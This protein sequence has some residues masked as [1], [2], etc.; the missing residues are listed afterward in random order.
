MT[1]SEL[2]QTD[3]TLHD[4]AIERRIAGDL[5]PELT[6]QFDAHIAQNA[7]CRS[8]YQQ[9]YAHEEAWTPPAL[10]L[11]PKHTSLGPTPTT[12]F[13]ANRPFGVR[14]ISMVG[15][16]AAAAA[17]VALFVTAEVKPE[18]MKATV[19]H[20]APSADDPIAITFRADTSG[21]A[22]LSTTAPGHAAVVEWHDDGSYR[23]VYP[24]QSNHSGVV[25]PNTRV[26]FETKAPPLKVVG[27]HCP[28]PFDIGKLANS[29]PP[30]T[31]SVRT[32]PAGC[33]QTR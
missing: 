5:S 32:L 9:A 11:P 22:T 12:N 6:A 2:F 29:Q 33:V 27:Y 26:E 1:T 24:A 3:G 15:L 4:L 21:R 30:T 7:S 28:S 14:T 25:G 31:G 10:N 13:A 16:S 23:V 19:G 8:R 18:Q 17:A 20:M